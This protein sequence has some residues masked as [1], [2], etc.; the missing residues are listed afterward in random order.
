M[1]QNSSYKCFVPEETVLSILQ[2]DRPERKLTAQT[3]T[4]P[5]YFREG[6]TF[7]SCGCGTIGG[8]VY[9]HRLSLC[10]AFEI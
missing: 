2:I 9:V 7:V 3:S 8:D 10:R 4:E 6:R 5:L 1:K